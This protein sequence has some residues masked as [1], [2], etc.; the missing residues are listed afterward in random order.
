[1]TEK[2]VSGQ[3]DVAG[4][5]QEVAEPLV[6]II[7][8]MQVSNVFGRP[9][10]EGDLTV[11][12]VASVTASFGYGFGYGQGPA[13]SAVAEGDPEAEKKG[14]DVEEAEDVEELE[15]TIDEIVAE[16]ITPEGGG[17][18]GGRTTTT[19]R[20]YIKITPDGVSYE[21]VFN[22]SIIPLAGIAL[23]AW[24]FFWIAMVLKAVAKR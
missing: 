3:L 8:R 21:P 12:P 6:R 1:M 15:Q 24:L 23:S 17:G 4:Q 10:T 20:G 2:D 9:S 7:D 11:I 13:P 22:P 5:I 14:P 19:P 18:G 16:A